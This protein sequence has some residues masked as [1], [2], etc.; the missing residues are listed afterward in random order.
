[1]SVMAMKEVDKQMSNM[2]NK[3]S[4]CFLFVQ[5][6][7]PSSATARAYR[8]SSNASLSTAMVRHKAYLHWYTDE[9]M[10]EMDFTEAKSNMNDL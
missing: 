8:S 7:S 3:N 4:S 6:P 2:Q 10:D 5:C 9:G 1:M